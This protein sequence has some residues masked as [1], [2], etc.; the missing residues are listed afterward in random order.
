[1]LW[2]AYYHYE[3]ANRGSIEVGKLTGY[4]LFDKKPQK[5]FEEE[6]AALKVF[7]TI[8]EGETFYIA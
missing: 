2:A 5:I 6:L 7:E 4:G 3:D 1:M 8:R